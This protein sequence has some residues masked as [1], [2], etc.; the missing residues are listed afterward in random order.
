MDG[1]KRKC[2]SLRPQEVC[3]RKTQSEFRKQRLSSDK[4]QG[5]DT[6]AKH[7]TK[8]SVISYKQL[9]TNALKAYHD[10]GNPAK[11]AVD[12]S[13]DFFHGLDNGRYT[14]FKVN[15]LRPPSKICPRI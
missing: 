2:E 10:Q 5:N 7:Q 4:A 13:M 11:D 8:K 14:N 12:Q 1:N 6:V 3:R 15:Y 9:Y